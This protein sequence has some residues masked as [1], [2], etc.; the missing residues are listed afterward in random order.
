MVDIPSPQSDDSW[1]ESVVYK[2]NSVLTLHLH[3][4]CILFFYSFFILCVSTEYNLCP[5]PTFKCINESTNATTQ[6]VQITIV[7]LRNNISLRIN[8]FS[9][10]NFKRQKKIRQHVCD[11][12]VPLDVVINTSSVDKDK[13][14]R[15]LQVID[16]G[17]PESC[18]LSLSAD[19]SP[20][21]R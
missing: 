18:A 7:A 17:P 20:F 1:T 14:E 15:R 19:L 9:L 6:L 11:L 4:N 2:H 13:T 8:G 3:F 10:S 5:P 12:Q 21:A 16:S